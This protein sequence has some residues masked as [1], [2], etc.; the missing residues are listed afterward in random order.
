MKKLVFVLLL[1]WLGGAG[2][3]WYWNE[4]RPQRI[5]F[6]SVTVKRG[7]L[8]ATINATGTLEPEE[9]V[10]VGVQIAGEILRFGADPRDSQR[11]ISYGSMVNEGTILAQLDDKLYLARLNQAKANVAKAEADVAQTQVKVKQTQRELERAQRLSKTR[12]AISAQEFDNTVSEA[13][14]AKANLLVSEGSL[15]LARANLDEAAVTLGYTTIKSPVKGVI[16]DR[17]V[18]IGQTV[19]ASLNA[20]SLFLIAKDLS[21][22]QIWASVNETDVGQI[23]PGQPV[24]FTVAAFPKETFRGKVDKIRLNASMSQSVV[25]YTVVVEVDNSAGKLLPYLTARLQFE[26]EE[27]RDVLLVPN[28]ALRWTPSVQQVS[29]SYRS[30]YTS[31]LRRQAATPLQ[32]SAPSRGKLFDH[33]GTLWIRELEYVRPL[34]IEVGLSDGLTSEISGELKEGTEVVV[35]LAE[36]E[37]DEERL[38]PFLPRIKNDKEKSK[39]R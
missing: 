22:M 29:P 31:S 35:G 27:R 21:K 14:I 10:D 5:L 17:R 20:P 8:L 15:A 33:K 11:A 19:V 39:S 1:M 25:T 26:V 34:P 37:G 30:E 12:G 38:S 9:V 3:L 32:K 7:N 24:A 36:N 2:G 13:D 18:N 4:G 23:Q 16:V 28:G 6:R